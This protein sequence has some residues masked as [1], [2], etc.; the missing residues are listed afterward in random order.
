MSTPA[1]CRE[2]R[3]PYS[4]YHG[5]TGRLPLCQLCTPSNRC[6][7]LPLFY[8][9]PAGDWIEL[10]VDTSS[11]DATGNATLHLSYL[12]GWMVNY[13]DA[14][15]S[16]TAG[17]ACDDM[18]FSCISDAMYT[19]YVTQQVQVRFCMPVPGRASG[20]AAGRR[21]VCQLVAS[22]PCVWLPGT[23]RMQV[24]RH[25]QCRL[26]VTVVDAPRAQPPPEHKVHLN[27]LFVTSY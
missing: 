1:N 23:P 10:Q 20:V 26:R 24:T 21:E 6:T 14:V 2:A 11:A 18:P 5:R 17:C 4:D 27:A 19:Q 15:L 16:C 25:P 22:V 13:G 3:L 8:W 12:R 7:H 9:T